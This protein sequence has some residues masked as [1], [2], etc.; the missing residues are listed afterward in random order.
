MKTFRNWL[1]PL[2]ITASIAF[3]YLAP[4]VSKSLKLTQNFPATVCPG[5]DSNGKTSVILPSKKIGIRDV[6]SKSLKPSKSHDPVFKVSGK[7]LLVDG[8]ATT[9]IT[10]SA[11][12][13]HWIGWTTCSLGDGDQW[14]V[15]GSATVT[16]KSRLDIVNS[17]LSDANVSITT[18]GSHQSPVVSN[19]LVKANSDKAISLDSLL[20]GESFLALHV[21][22]NSGRVT[23]FLFDQERKGL[24]DLGMD[25]VNSI[26][27]PSTSLIIPAVFNNSDKKATISHSLRLLAPGTFD[28]SIKVTIHG[29]DGSY[30][31]LGFDQITLTHGRV[32]QIPL[33]SIVETTPFS[34]EISSDQPI[35]GSVRSQYTQGGVTDFAWET[36]APPL[37]SVSMNLH[38]ATPYFVFNGDQLNVAINWLSTTGKRGSVAVVGQQIGLWHPTSPISSITLTSQGT[39]TQAGAI[40]QSSGTDNFGLSYLPVAQGSTMETASAPVV[41]AGVI[42]RG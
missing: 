33:Q 1:I 7:P 34:I 41:S 11:L 35:V 26:A 20:P 23:S 6:G 24:T 15:G 19:V 40:F 29:Q 13:G 28:A 30:T 14:F 18:Y 16:S 42:S 22:T 3:T 25:Y 17:G 39:T 2:L 31:P 10:L 5:L 37:T 9:S 12:A 8:T 21:L 32:R 4:H 27:A 38:G 36:P